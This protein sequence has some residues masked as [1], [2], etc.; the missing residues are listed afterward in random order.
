MF[1]PISTD[2]RTIAESL[3]QTLVD[4]HAQLWSGFDI[5]EPATGSG[6][7]RAC[8]LTRHSMD[9]FPASPEGTKCKRIRDCRTHAC[10]LRNVM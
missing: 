6:V 5:S 8:V 4:R 1:R 9:V 10:M 7:S 2:A 3:A